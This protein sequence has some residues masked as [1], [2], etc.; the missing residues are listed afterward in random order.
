MKGEVRFR[1][2]HLEVIELPNTGSARLAMKQRMQGRACRACDYREH[3]EAAQQRAAELGL[4]ALRGAPKQVAYGS[5][6]RARQVDLFLGT[7]ELTRRADPEGR[8]ARLLQ[9]QLLSTVN[10]LPDA[11][12]WIEH[13]SPRVLHSLLGQRWREEQDDD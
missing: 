9:E 2:G 3:V 11:A 10:A 8:W 4:I 1:C 5:L 6:L 7:V 12:W 13:Q